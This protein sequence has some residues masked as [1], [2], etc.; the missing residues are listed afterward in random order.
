MEHQE[1][2]A[3]LLQS[4]NP[5]ET[6]SNVFLMLIEDDTLAT[7]SCQNG[8]SFD[9]FVPPLLKSLFNTMATNLIAEVNDKC[10]PKR[11]HGPTDKNDPATKKIAKLTSDKI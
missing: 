6:F 2:K 10:L 1:A 11:T 3:F 9:K 8:H 5:R 4:N 7:G